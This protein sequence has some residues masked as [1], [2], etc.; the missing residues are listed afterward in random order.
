M[1]CMNKL[2]F[3]LKITV[4][5]FR[6]QCIITETNSR[7][8]WIA[9]LWQS[10]DNMAINICGYS[11]PKRQIFFLCRGHCV[12]QVFM[13]SIEIVINLTAPLNILKNYHQQRISSP[14]KTVKLCMLLWEGV[15]GVLTSWRVQSHARRISNVTAGHL[16]TLITGP[17]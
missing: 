11:D 1:L 10:T 6:S 9:E 7:R 14:L 15:N 5:C 16:C 4:I 3:Y 13:A 12:V 2:T 17:G 8:P